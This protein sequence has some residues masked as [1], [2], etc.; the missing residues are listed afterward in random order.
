[1]RFNSFLSKTLLVFAGISTGFGVGVGAF[2]AYYWLWYEVYVNISALDA[3]IFVDE[4]VISMGR[5][6]GEGFRLLEGAPLALLLIILGLI[7]LLVCLFLA[8]ME[9]SYRSPG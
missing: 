5:L 9:K 7:L 2:Q 1:M 4:H 3:F 8:Q 6:S